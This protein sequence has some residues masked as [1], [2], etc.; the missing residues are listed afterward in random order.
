M[1]NFKIELKG[2][3]EEAA[4][5]EAAQAIIRIAEALKWPGSSAYRSVS[6]ETFL[7]SRGRFQGHIQIR[8]KFPPFR[9]SDPS[10]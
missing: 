1:H 5:Q 3:A 9:A 8:V 4:D 6:G 7:H 10:M 2:S